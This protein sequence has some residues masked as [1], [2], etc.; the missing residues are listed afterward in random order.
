MRSIVA[1]V[2]IA[3]VAVAACGSNPPASPSGSAAAPESA[4]PVTASSSP[5]ASS[6]A[7]AGQS[8]TVRLPAK[9]GK[10]VKIIVHDPG[11]VLT[12]VR[13]P[14]SVE[15]SDVGRAPGGGDASIVG[16]KNPKSV[17]VGWAASVCDK[18]VE[19]TVQGT[20]VIVAP[21]PRPDCD[22]MAVDR[23]VTLKFAN[24]VDA[25]GM[26]ATYVPPTKAP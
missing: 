19:L 7:A 11:K 1:L 23:A 9:T 18:K 13:V 20:F 6:S 8:F 25:S 3:I 15:T 22:A 16:G 12:G 26:T 21:A 10:G 14:T 24:K 4:P 17:V 5:A 2:G